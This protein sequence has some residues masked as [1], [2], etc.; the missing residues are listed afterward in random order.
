VLT[1]RDS[2]ATRAI[3]PHAFVA[4]L[5]VDVGPRR[6]DLRFTVANPGT[7]PLAW[8]GTLHTFLAVAAR[9]ARLRGLGP[10]RYV[11][12]G[13]GSRPAEDPGDEVA[14]PGHIDRVYLDADRRVEVDDGTR[15]VAVDKAGFRDTVVWNPGPETSRRFDDLEPD[16]HGA[17]VCVE[18]AEVRPVS[19][20]A[21]GVWTGRQTLTWLDPPAPKRG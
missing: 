2:P 8:S 15:R 21:G 4:E 6:L 9:R 16:D 18:A 14:V 20:P 19:V 10:G 13:R 7:G 12:R 3:W 17:F 5:A 11:D 1:L